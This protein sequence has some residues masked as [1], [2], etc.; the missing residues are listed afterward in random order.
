MWKQPTC[1]LEERALDQKA[2][3]PR[4]VSLAGTG[5]IGL[6]F[7]SCSL[8]LL[9]VLKASS[10]SVQVLYLC[11]SWVT[12]QDLTSSCSVP[13]IPLLLDNF[14]SLYLQHEKTLVSKSATL[15]G[16]AQSLPHK[17]SLS[18]YFL[19]ISPSLEASWD[20]A[21]SPC[22]LLPSTQPLLFW[23]STGSLLTGSS[24]PQGR[25]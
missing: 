19:L 25:V 4:F 5:Q 17:A 13:F 20:S 11:W 15:Q 2:S 16:Q 3:K 14:L 9:Q 24:A 23:G 7:F 1:G 22:S 21:S 8:S 18:A 12:F 10:S 6:S